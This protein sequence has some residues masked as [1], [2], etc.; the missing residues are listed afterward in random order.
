MIIRQLICML[1]LLLICQ[2]S[3]LTD[4]AFSTVVVDDASDDGRS[5]DKDTPVAIADEDDAGGDRGRCDE[6]GLEW[7]GEEV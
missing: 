5:M 7:N 1:I 6:D 2:I 4:N 3:A